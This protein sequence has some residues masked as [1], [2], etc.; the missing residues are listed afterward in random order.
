[1]NADEI[2]ESAVA[3]KYLI[4]RPKA[5]QWYEDG[6]L[7]KE[8]S[9][10]ER[11][12]GRFELFLDLLYVA[13]V[14]NFAEDLADGP[15]GAKV[16]KYVLIFAAAWQVWSD[17]REIM[18]SYYTDD[19]VQRGLVLWIMALLVVYGNNATLVGDEAADPGAL[20]TTVAA[21]VAARLTVAAVYVVCSFASYA[22]RPQAR[23]M[24]AC[25]VAGL[26]LWA[27]LFVDD[28]RVGRRAKVAVAAVAVV[29]NE[30]AW[31]LTFGPWIK[32]RL[33]LRYS[34][35]VDI[36]HEIDRLA[37]FF[38]V[39]LGEYL[40]SIVVG[41]PG[42][43]GLNT[44]LLR[45]VCT[46]VVAFCLNWLYVNGDG[47]VAPV[48]HPIRRSAASAF[49]FFSLHM[50]LAASLLVGGHVCA[51]SAAKPDLTPPER[52]LL[53]AGLGIG[54]FCLWILAML[55][56]S[57]PDRH[58]PSAPALTL[59][60]PL[61]VGMRLVVAIVLCLLPLASPATLPVV[62]LLCTVAGLFV[63]VVVWETVGGLV[64]GA[65]VYER[66]GPE[67][68]MPWFSPFPPPPP[69]PSS[70]PSFSSAPAAFPS[71]QSSSHHP[72][73]FLLHLLNFPLAPGAAAAAA[74]AGA[75]PRLDSEG[76]ETGGAPAAEPQGG[77]EMEEEHG[78][79]FDGDRDC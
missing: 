76:R 34:T 62:A 12:A 4:K 55:F 40:Y 22:H 27:P 73:P 29:Y 47:G 65:G 6:R 64:R 5:L 38:T 72:P 53:G 30:A 32:R 74:A 52:W 19:L 37:A 11:Q 8:G 9:G 31:I 3:S 28:D 16:V 36:A 56:K 57:P 67:K 78:E 66:W 63:F 50:P 68:D 58:R 41:D 77:V 14:A 2:Q 43:V 61:R 35:A 48:V 75:R 17:V 39:I 44:R 59:P 70:S 79:K 1:M 71:S 46:L 51:A 54:T 24:A 21:F 10:E 60:K 33:R 13:L 7:V 42:A 25:I 45:A 15:T 49:A 23:V 69:P 20:R 18:N 26:A